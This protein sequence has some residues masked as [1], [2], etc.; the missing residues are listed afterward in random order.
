M[1]FIYVFC[2]SSDV[3]ILSHQRI[4]SSGGRG[5]AGGSRINGLNQELGLGFYKENHMQK[6]LYQ[7]LLKRR[8]LLNIGLY[9][10]SI[11]LNE[12]FLW[13]ADVFHLCIL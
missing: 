12:K 9:L 11:K 7:C 3:E 4:G 1:F 8:V 13:T 5:H 6:I 2:S 10:G